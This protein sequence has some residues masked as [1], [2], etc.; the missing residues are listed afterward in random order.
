LE[1][2]AELRDREPPRL[3]WRPPA[4]DIQLRLHLD[5]EGQFII[6][7]ARDTSA[8]EKN[9]QAGDK[10]IGQVAPSLRRRQACA[11]MRRIA[12]KTPVPIFRFRLLCLPETS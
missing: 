7:L 1:E 8:L 4:P 2:A 12:S 5:V 6:H 10:P 9:T 3:A 11:S